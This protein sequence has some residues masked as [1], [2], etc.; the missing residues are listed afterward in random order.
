M[1]FTFTDSSSG[2]PAKSPNG[3]LNADGSNANDPIYVP[4]NT[5]AT[6]EITFN[7]TTTVSVAQQRAALE[8]VIERTPCLRRQR[9]RILARNSCVAPWVHTSS[10][11]VRQSLPGLAGHEATVEVEVFNLL[12][13]IRR[14]WGLSRVP[15]TFLLKQVG[16]TAGTAATSQPIFFFDPNWQ[17]YNTANA[18]SAYQL[19]IAMRYRF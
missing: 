4:R 16:Q 1:P 6:A 7:P 8:S 5:A 13:L 15:N 3:D 18:E 19:Q 17:P 9:G 2:D 12:N 14:D 11:A 10:A